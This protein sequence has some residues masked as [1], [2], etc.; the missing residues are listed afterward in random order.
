MVVFRLNL[1]FIAKWYLEAYG[2]VNPQIC[3][4]FIP[5]TVLESL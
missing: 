5:N 4:L 3:F 2:L 1:N